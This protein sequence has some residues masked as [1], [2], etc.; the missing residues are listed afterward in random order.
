MFTVA[1]L[2][3]A[4]TPAPV[5]ASSATAQSKIQIIKGNNKKG[6]AVLAPSSEG[7]GPAAGDSAGSAQAA[8]SAELQKQAADLDAKQKA[9]EAREQELQA[10]EK[11]N[12]D[13]E[14]KKAERQRQLQRQIERMGQQNQKAWQNANNALVDGE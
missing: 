4:L 13:A 9:L 7:P 14:A 3:L 5:V 12:E 8:K 6:A 1:A 10:K 2:V 11:A